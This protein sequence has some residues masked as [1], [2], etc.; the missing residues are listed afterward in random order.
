MFC[1]FS[2]SFS[3]EI[4]TCKKSVQ[5]WMAWLNIMY[6]ITGFYNQQIIAL[7][8][9]SKKTRGFVMRGTT[10]RWF[11][12]LF[13]CSPGSGCLVFFWSVCN[14]GGAS[15]LKHDD[16]LPGG[17]FGRNWHIYH[18]GVPS[19]MSTKKPISFEK[20]KD[21]IFQPSFFQEKYVGFSGE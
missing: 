17:F 20:G 10:C 11:L 13:F 5:F 21:H 3:Y 8:I 19:N 9:N 6:I 7:V 14:A 12:Y 4:K 1:W 15:H 2:E 18:R 16:F